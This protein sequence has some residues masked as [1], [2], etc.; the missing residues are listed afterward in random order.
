MPTLTLQPQGQESPIPVE[1]ETMTDDILKVMVEDTQYALKLCWEAP[2]GGWVRNTETGEVIPFYIWVQGDAVSL[3]MKGKIYPFT[4]I[5]Q[6]AKRQAGTGAGAHSHSGEVKA[7]MPGTILKIM[8]TPGETV[9]ANVPLLIME[10]M[11]MEMTLTTPTAGTVTKVLCEEGQ[12]V[13]MNT[14]LISVAPE[15]DESDVP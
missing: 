9:E 4:A 10:S 14:L 12:L 3:W 8:V 2:H 5:S 13:E 15:K 7:P 1:L 11:K 6:Q